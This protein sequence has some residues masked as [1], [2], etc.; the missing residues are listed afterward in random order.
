LVGLTTRSNLVGCST[1][2]AGLDPVQ[3]LV[4]KSRLRAPRASVMI[5][6]A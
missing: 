4:D 6:S 5:Q 2:I 1:G 3:N